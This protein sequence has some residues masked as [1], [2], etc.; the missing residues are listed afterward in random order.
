MTLRSIRTRRGFTLIE[1]MIVVAIIGILA[2]IAIPN[3][4]QQV[5]RAKQS[6]AM[7]MLGHIK[8]GQLSFSAAHDCFIDIPATPAGPPG[9]AR[10]AWVPAAPTAAV[11]CNGAPFSFEDLAIR[12]SGGTTYYSYACN[13]TIPGLDGPSSE[14]TCTALGDLDGNGALY[15]LAYCSDNDNNGAGIATVAGTACNFPGEQVRLSADRF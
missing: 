7:I 8:T 14:F 2:A 3:Y 4:L 15:E 1:I 13:A 12:P 10:M 6:E 9:P 11:V 5:L